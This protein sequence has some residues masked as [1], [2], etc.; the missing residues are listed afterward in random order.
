ML[1]E[2]GHD[3]GYFGHGLGNIWAAFL[4][5]AQALNGCSPLPGERWTV[6]DD[7]T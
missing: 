5:P 2:N 3:L 7:R 4:G 6:L 1:P